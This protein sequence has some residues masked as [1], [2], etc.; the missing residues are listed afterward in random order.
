MTNPAPSAVELIDLHKSY[1]TTVAVGGINL[2]VRPGEFL[3]LL[4]PSGCGKTT[5][6]S[7]IAGFVEPDR[8]SIRL[9]GRQVEKLPPFR[10]DI[11][12]VFQ[13]Y[14]LFPHMDVATNVGF[15][16]R[17]R[18]IGRQEAALRVKD[19]LELVQLGALG[20]RRPAALS[21]GQRQRVALAR[22]LV[23]R[24]AVLLLDEP[25]SNLDLKL[26][27]EMRLE[28]SAVQKRTGITTILVTHDQGE[29]L[30][31]SDRIAVMRAGQV[32]QIGEPNNIYENPKTR[33]V[34]E[35]I[36]SMNFLSGQVE[37]PAQEDERCPV[38]T[39]GGIVECSVSHAVKKGDRVL[40]AVRPERLRVN[41][42]P[43]PGGM[44]IDATIEQFVY[45]GNKTELRA[46][47]RS[48]ETFLL[49]QTNDGIHSGYTTGEAIRLT[50]RASDLRVF[51][52]RS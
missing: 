20:H 24:P 2:T 14:A 21:G 1:G 29:A 5:T 48:G 44:S 19:A 34:A 23:I 40:I 36:G 33:F 28:I 41:E 51:P 25:L 37:A 43:G 12:L 47:G 17:M 38:K 18:G 9:A 42:A 39:A 13:D 6:L 26:R 27:E 31:V 52:D 3:A 22:A 50:A 16:L 8:G 35:F 46:R 15:G 30:A 7:M 10:R 49:E 11:G 32:E 4:G 45:L